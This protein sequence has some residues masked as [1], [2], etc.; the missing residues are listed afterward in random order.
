MRK[1]VLFDLD[2][3]I[4]DHQYSRRSA[5]ASLLEHYPGVIERD[6][7][8]LE[9]I[10][11][12]HLQASF[13]DLLAGT[14]K[15]ADARRDRIRG[16]FREIGYPL[17]EEDLI[18]ANEIYR[19]AYDAIRRAVP[20][21]V[22]VINA[23][24]ETMKIAIVT[25]GLGMRQEEKIRL[26]GLEGHFD[27]IVTSEKVG[28]KKPHRAIFDAALAALNVSA[29]ETVMF[30]DSWKSDVLGARNAGIHA[31]WFNRYDETCPDPNLAA[32]V[33]SLEPTDTIVSLL[34]G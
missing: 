33:T 22:P 18:R 20:G 6:I 1:A 24:K 9:L 32:E 7:K 16:L 10:H 19:S 17:S 21:V 15:R 5:L 8:K 13:D 2:D 3:T 30:G 4:S 28:V 25:N 27:A 31:V 23:L 14:I 26:C 12:R 34:K 11:E 29:S